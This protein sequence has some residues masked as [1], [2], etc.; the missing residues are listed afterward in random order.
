[1]HHWLR[2]HE[3]VIFLLQLHESF[4]EVPFSKKYEILLVQIHYVMSYLSFYFSLFTVEPCAVF[5]QNRKMLKILTAVSFVQFFRKS[6]LLTRQR[7][8]FSKR[9]ISQG[10]WTC[11]R[12]RERVPH[13]NCPFSSFI[14]IQYNMNKILERNKYS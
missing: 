6:L 7:S 8:K 5:Q 4:S 2:I 10:F 3:D 9:Q 12:N 14:T 1:M 11:R 13:F